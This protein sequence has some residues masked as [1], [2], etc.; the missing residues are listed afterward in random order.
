MLMPKIKD[1]FKFNSDAG[2]VIGL[3]DNKSCAFLSL[4]ESYVAHV[5]GFN[6]AKQLGYA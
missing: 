3:I 6:I 1:V 5:T 2:A 4:F